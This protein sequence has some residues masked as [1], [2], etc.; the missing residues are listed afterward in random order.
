MRRA[1]V[2]VLSV[3]SVVTTILAL[4]IVPK[5]GTA[6]HSLLPGFGQSVADTVPELVVVIVVGLIP[7]VIA[8]GLFPE[9]GEPSVTVARQRPV[10]TFAVGLGFILG[11]VGTVGVALF[12]SVV[13]G[14]FL[15]A[16][17]LM[18]YVVL[19][20][21]GY[22]VLGTVVA[23]RFGRDSCWA[24]L[25][26]TAPVSVPMVGM[27]AASTPVVV[28]DFVIAA[29]GVG[30]F[31]FVWRGPGAAETEERRIPPAYRR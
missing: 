4:V 7:G 20:A 11:G 18:L 23:A 30:G 25:L 31:M 6:A 15:G 17:A 24:G 29:F 22:V 13:F 28:L 21:I 16:I 1:A 9:I 12:L 5:L 27:M 14:L 10:R 2:A 19:R 3:G 8:I 26:I